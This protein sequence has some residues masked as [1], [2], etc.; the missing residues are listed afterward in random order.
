MTRKRTIQVYGMCIISMIVLGAFTDR[1]IESARIFCEK[2]LLM[3]D[4]HAFAT[5]KTDCFTGWAYAM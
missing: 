3:Y 1:A 2:T 4:P 5:G